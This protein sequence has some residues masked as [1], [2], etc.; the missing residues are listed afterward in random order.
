MDVPKA[1]MGQLSHTW[2]KNQLHF[3]PTPLLLPRQ[4]GTDAEQNSTP[5]FANLGQNSHLKARARGA[6]VQPLKLTQH[7]HVAPYAGAAHRHRNPSSGKS[8]LH[9][10]SRKSMTQR[11]VQKMQL[12]HTPLSLFATLTA[13]SP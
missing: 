5:L 11:L 10:F 2:P 3:C 9:T 4:R 6:A 12:S 8:F 1:L 7:I 13:S